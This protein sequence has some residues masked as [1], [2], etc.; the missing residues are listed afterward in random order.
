MQLVNLSPVMTMKFL[1]SIASLKACVGISKNLCKGTRPLRIKT[2][3][4]LKPI[5]FQGLVV[6]L[7]KNFSIKTIKIKSKWD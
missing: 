1:T 6:Y 7:C 3:K 2:Q 4:A 5:D